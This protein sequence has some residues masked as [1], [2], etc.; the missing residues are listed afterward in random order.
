MNDPHHTELLELHIAQTEKLASLTAAL[1]L[2]GDESEERLAAQAKRLAN[3]RTLLMCGAREAIAY[4]EPVANAPVFYVTA[5]AMARL[6]L[7][8]HAAESPLP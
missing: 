3:D 6:Q 1:G 8:L 2:L 4:S 7:A 5:Q